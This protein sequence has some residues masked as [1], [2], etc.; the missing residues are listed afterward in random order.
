M[1]T[2]AGVP[3][4]EKPPDDGAAL[5]AGLLHS[6]AL[7][8][9]EAMLQDHP[10][11]GLILTGVLG[12]GPVTTLCPLSQKPP[13]QPPELWQGAGTI[14]LMGGERKPCPLLG[15]LQGLPRIQ[16]FE[17]HRPPSTTGQQLRI[18][19]PGLC[20]TFSSWSRRRRWISRTTASFCFS[21]LSGSSRILCF[22]SSMACRSCSTSEARNRPCREE[23]PPSAGAPSLC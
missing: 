22:H 13:P 8:L 10:D 12:G 16:M 20:C 11:V 3:G 19:L 2:C 18:T 21:E 1:L 23:P 5:V 6:L 14:Q 7:L 17:N 4:L 15:G 9:V